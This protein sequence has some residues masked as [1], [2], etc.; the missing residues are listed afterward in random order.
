M[1]YFSYLFEPLTIPMY[2]RTPFVVILYFFVFMGIAQNSDYIRGKVLDANTG[3][4]IVFANI[5]IKDRALG[6]ITNEDGGF[7]IPTKYRDY[8]EIIEVSSMGYSTLEILVTE[9]VQEDYNIL[10]LS[11]KSI[12]LEE[13]IVKGRRKG[14]NRLSAKQIVQ[15]ALDAIPNNYPSTSFSAIGYYRDYQLKNKEYWNMNEALLEVFDKGFD[16]FDDGTSEIR[17]YNYGLNNDFGNDSLARSAYDYEG[18]LKIID[19]AYLNVLGGNEFRTLRI[20]DAIR[21]YNTDTFDFLGVP[22]NDLVNNHFFLRSSDTSIDNEDLYTIKFWVFH[23]N[24]RANGTLYISQSDFAIYRLEYTMYDKKNRNKERKT[25]KHGHKQKVIFDIGTEYRRIDGKMYLNYISFHNTFILHIP[26]LFKVDYIDVDT[27]RQRFIVNYNTLPESK[28]AIDASNYTISF[29][30]WVFK[31]RKVERLQNK[32]YLYPDLSDDKIATLIKDIVKAKEDGLGLEQI[33]NIKIEKMKDLN[34]NKLNEWGKEEYLQFR[35]FFVQRIKPDSR[36]PLDNL[37]MKMN[38]P[39]SIDQP[40]AKPMDFE[41]YWMN[42][43][44]I[45]NINIVKSP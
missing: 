1:W 12:N 6:I 7:R 45:D 11:P 17:L 44:L 4:P 33:L 3:E 23:P 13:A 14:R 5:R 38:K 35:E 18:N 2:S 22:K 16:Q 25:N 24:Y 19:K 21:N 43:P 29:H 27:N 10:K 40:I 15:R 42:T 34:G 31:P 28:A 30:N 39:L 41:D 26:P 8:G 32:V 36:A 37:F 20:H 9:L